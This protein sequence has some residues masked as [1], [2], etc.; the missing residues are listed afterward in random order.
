MRAPS[1]KRESGQRLRPGISPIGVML[2]EVGFPRRGAAARRARCSP[3]SIMSKCYTFCHA[4]LA[5]TRQLRAS[6]VFLYVPGALVDKRVAWVAYHRE[7]LRH[8]G[9]A[10]LGL[11]MPE[12][13]RPAP[14]LAPRPVDATDGATAD[15][16]RAPLV[17]ATGSLPDAH[18]FR[19]GTHDAIS[20]GRFR[21]GV[22]RITASLPKTAPSD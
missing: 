14:R 13:P 1:A 6:W 16:V 4:K 21:A 18:Y 19:R 12:A 22:L 10:P 15:A 7:Y 8:Y 5:A 17:D 9:M 2:L 20:R 11:P 3:G